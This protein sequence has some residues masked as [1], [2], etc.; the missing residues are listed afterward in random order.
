MPIKKQEKN[1]IQKETDVKFQ[2]LK[3]EKRA[4]F[5]TNKVEINDK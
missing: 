4:L 5:V 3:L 2:M 1:N